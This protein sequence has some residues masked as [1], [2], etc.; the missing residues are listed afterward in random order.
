MPKSIASFIFPS[1]PVIDAG[2]FFYRPSTL[3][4]RRIRVTAQSFKRRNEVAVA[5][6]PH[7]NRRVPPHSAEFGPAHG[8]AAKITLETL[9]PSFRPATRARDS[10]APR[11][12]ETRALCRRGLP[13]PGTHVLAD[14]AAENVPAHAFAQLFGN[15]A[16]LFDGEIRDAFVRV[17]LVGARKALVGQA[18]RQRVQVPQRS[19]AGKSGTRSSDVRMTPRKSQEPSF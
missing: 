13:I 11:E 16:A 17:Q 14:V 15:R 1:A 18:S 3:C 7:G 10:P 8:R 5:A 12:A 4:D 9:P 19:G 6:V 2:Q